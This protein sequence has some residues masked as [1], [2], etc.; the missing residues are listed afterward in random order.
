LKPNNI[1]MSIE[2][3]ELFLQ[4]EAVALRDKAVEKERSENKRRKTYA[5]LLLSVEE[6]FQEN[7]A[8]VL[9]FLQR[10]DQH[11]EYNDNTYAQWGSLL[12]SSAHYSGSTSLGVSLL[13]DHEYHSNWQYFSNLAGFYI[14]VTKLSKEVDRKKQ[15]AQREEEYRQ[16]RTN[17]SPVQYIVPELQDM[18]N[19][20]LHNVELEPAQL[21]VAAQIAYLSSKNELPQYQPDEPADDATT[22]SEEL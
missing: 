20:I 1:S 14:A 3:T 22:E 9:P 15:E 21:L 6:V 8:F 18:I 10:H 2:Q 13:E 12:F 16:Q 7:A 5:D 11:S 4:A 17:R 19:R